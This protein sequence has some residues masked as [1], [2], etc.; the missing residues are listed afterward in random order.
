MTIDRDKVFS[1]L[2]HDR[3]TGKLAATVT[4]SSVRY[5]AS[6]RYP[7]QLE[8]LLPDGRVVVGQFHNGVFIP[9]PNPVD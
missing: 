2:E 1:D 8:Q 4:T 3:R 7:G 5:Q 6:S 9:I